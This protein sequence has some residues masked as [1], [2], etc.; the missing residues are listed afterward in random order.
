M[1]QKL[2]F[3][4]GFF[5]ILTFLSSLVVALT[6][7]YLSRPRPRNRLAQ[8]DKGREKPTKLRTGEK[9]DSRSATTN[10]TNSDQVTETNIPLDLP[11]KTFAEDTSLEGSKVT[12]ITIVPKI[13]KVIRPSGENQ[14]EKPII[15]ELSSVKPPLPPA[16]SVENQ[17]PQII[18]LENEDQGTNRPKDI[19]EPPNGI[20][21]PRNSE[22]VKT[23]NI[24]TDKPSPGP[25]IN[26]EKGGNPI[27]PLPLTKESA[28]SEGKESMLNEPKEPQAGGAQ[29]DRGFSDLFT[30]DTEETQAG[31]LSKELS[32]IETDDIL[33]MSHSLVTQLRG[34]RPES[35]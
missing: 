14:P 33:T 3:A 23:T 17:Q 18:P 25:E 5:I 22:E 32:D 2:D 27:N 4:L 26:L 21:S 24:R 11:S 12:E 15:S 35:R 16:S 20:V 29:D 7:I 9:S 30:E 28:A 34:R 1:Y 19:P 31:K 13:G 10:Q 8:N 6:L